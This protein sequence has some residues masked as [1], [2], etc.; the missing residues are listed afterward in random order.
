MPKKIKKKGWKIEMER[1]ILRT[2][3]NLSFAGKIVENNLF[4]GKGLLLRT[5]PKY[6][7]KIWCPFDEISSIIA[8]GEVINKDSITGELEKLM[9][10][11]AD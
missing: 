1:I 2:T 3:S 8:D 11:K 5:N 10:Y 6:Q 4:E 7:M 9:C